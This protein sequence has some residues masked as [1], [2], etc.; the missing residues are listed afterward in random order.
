VV[1]EH[2]LDM[3]PGVELHCLKVADLVDL[4]NAA[5]YAR[6]Q[7]IDIVNHSVGWAIASYYDDTGAV[8]DLVNQSRDVDGVFWAVASGNNAR[9]HWRGGWVDEDVDDNLDFAPGDDSLRLS[10]VS[11]NVCLYLNWNQYGLSNTNLD[12]FVTDRYGL[13]TASSQSPQSGWQAPVEQVCFPYS[14]G[15]APYDVTI[16]HRAGPTADLDVTLFSFFNEVEYPIASAALMDPA[17][18]HGAFTV[19]AVNQWSWGNPWPPI[20]LYSSQGPTTDGRLKPDLIGPDGT[21]SSTYGVQGGWGTSFSA[22]T[23]AGAAALLLHNDPTLTPDALA[24]QLA[25]LAHDIGPAG[26]DPIY[27]NGALSVG[28]ESVFPD[29]ADGD[30]VVDVLDNCPFE[31]NPAQSDAGGVSSLLADGIG[32]ACQCADVTGDGVVLLDDLS[33]IQ[34]HLIGAPLAPGAAPLC[35]AIGAAD[36]GASDCGILDVTVIRRALAAYLPGI[37]QVCSPALP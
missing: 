28:V 3:A 19:G 21:T 12:L 31:P 16:E 15:E 33:A 14:S 18:A 4:E 32:D 2:V 23:A 25:V 35:N 10:Q 1:A 37:G 36:G 30:G 9:R 7:G 20:Q 34:Q 27:G 22:A 8:S 6:T 29:D 11:S 17:A 13:T 26:P 24:L 5:D